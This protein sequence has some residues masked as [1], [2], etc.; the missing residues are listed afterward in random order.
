MRSV[1]RRR[2]INVLAL[3]SAA[4]ACGR[5]SSSPDIPA[6]VAKLRNTNPSVRGPANVE[7][8]RLGEPAALPVSEL[9]KD[10]DPKIRHLA[11]LTLAS[12]G[13]KARPA[14]APLIAALDDS[15][16]DV[17]IAAATALQPIGREAAAGVPA[18]IRLLR[19]SN[20]TVRREAARALGE[21]GAPAA[22]AVPALVQASKN[23]YM[24]DA[25]DE[26]VRKI[27]SSR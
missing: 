26:A 16:D 20:G 7:L 12:M 21:I 15:S 19:D 18:L 8:I 5:W 9:L 25:A 4:A 10:P 24:Q 22:S 23:D 17:R 2:L 3:A 6:L 1:T 13:A 11:A 27:Q 14:V